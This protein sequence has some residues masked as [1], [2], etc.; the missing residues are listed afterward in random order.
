MALEIIKNI[1]IDFYDKKYIMV[2]AKQYDDRSRYVAITCYNQGDIFNLKSNEHSAYVRYKKADG[3]S[4]LNYCRINYR[5]EVLVELTEQM[6]SA[7][8]ICYV[9]LVIVNK[10]NTIVNIDNGEIIAIDESPILSTMAFCVNVYES[11]VDNSEFESSYEYDALNELLQK[12]EAD[13]TEIIQ[14]SKS[15]AVGNAGGI[16][17]NENADNAKYYYEQSLVNANDA[18]ASETNAAT[19][20]SNAKISEA[21]AKASET[22]AATSESNASASEKNA[23]DYSVVSQRYAIGGTNTVPGEDADNAKYY[24]GQIKGVY[25]GLDGSLSPKGTIVFEE[26]AT[27]EKFTGALYVMGDSFVTDETFVEG[28]DVSYPAGT[29]VYYTVDGLWA[30]F[31]GVKSDIATVDEVKSYLGI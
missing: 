31:E 8:G 29:L 15:Y 4:V 30:T 11:S 6:L 18:K 1:N 22:N 26:L 3:H 13:Y 16:R 24:Y 23:Y 10:G 25:D 28:E 19:S 9:D 5:G 27:A 21:N 2:N 17:D 12:A 14:L 7:D 20:E